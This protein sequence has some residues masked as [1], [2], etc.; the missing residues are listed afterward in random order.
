M[1]AL[2]ALLPI[3][4]VF[5]LSGCSL[6]LDV[7]DFGSPQG[8]QGKGKFI[9]DLEVRAQEAEALETM[10]I[11]RLH[12]AGLSGQGV[13]IF[14]M[15]PFKEF[16]PGA[17]VP[18]GFYLEQLIKAIA[19]GAQV[20]PCDTGG[21][22][23]SIEPAQF[24]DCFLEALFQK[25]DLVIVGAMGWDTTQEPNC[26]DL[27]DGRL[28]R[29]QL[30]VFAGAGDSA[31]EGLSYP[32]C[33]SGVIPVLATYDADQSGE[34]PFLRNCWR[35]SIHKDELACFTN[36]IEGQTLLAAP[37]AIITLDL[38]GVDI[39]YCC[40]TAI[41]ATLLGASVALLME[42]YPNATVAEIVQALRETGVPIKDA[43]GATVGLRAAVNR[44]YLLLGESLRS[45][46]TSEPIAQSIRDFD[47]N[48][49]CY[50]SI[51][52]FS[53]AMDAWVKGEVETELFYRVMDAWVSQANVCT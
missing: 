14:L 29:S 50:I 20:I 44:A 1:R 36:Y 10:G 43:K 8:T 13:S 6:G 39:P 35:E 48:Q 25:P 17:N 37:G 47:I 53:R 15:A 18:V 38:F 46:P 22:F 40:S 11:N 49:D 21:D 27:L 19:P 33:V 32:A 23:F 16:R 51:E 5:L 28:A 2:T 31:I 30:T 9:S 41:A 4:A 45:E 42:A 26:D 7:Q 52:E 34:L 12:E 3:L 24:A